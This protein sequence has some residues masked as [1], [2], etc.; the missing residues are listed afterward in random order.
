MLLPIKWLKN[1]VDID[2]DSRVLAD[3]LTDSGSHV[4]SINNRAAGLSN[5][6]VGKIEKI[7]KH[8]NAD[9]LVIC[10]INVGAADNITIVTGAKN[11]F[12]G[13]LVPV[14]MVGAT[15][16]ND[17]KIVSGDLRGVV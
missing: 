13:A 3:G 7:E 9:K 5:V 1:Y 12:E 6:I 16:A 2:V 17:L 15:L 11:V 14:A 4:E 10:D 8:P